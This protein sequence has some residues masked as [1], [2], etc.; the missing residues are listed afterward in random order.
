[1]A[2]QT[3]RPNSQDEAQPVEA[4]VDEISPQT[5]KM[6]DDKLPHASDDVKQATMALVD[7]IKKRAKSQARTTGQWT[8]AAYIEAAQQAKDL[9]SQRQEL[10]QKYKAQLDNSLEWIEE[11]ANQRWESLSKEAE[12]WGERLSR[13]ADSAWRILSGSEE[14]AEEEP[15]SAST[16]PK[17]C[18]TAQKRALSAYNQVRRKMQDEEDQG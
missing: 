2:E 13:A 12:S 4:V 16:P 8:R 9:L 15:D 3:S 10:S 18:A 5:Q 7:A 6:V 17:Q 1:M 14:Q 11:E